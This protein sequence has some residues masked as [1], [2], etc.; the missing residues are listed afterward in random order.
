MG[1]R[2][3]LIR[4]DLNG[5]AFAGSGFIVSD[6]AVLTA[7]HVAAGTRHRV[8]LDGTELAVSGCV[9]SG[10]EEVDLAVLTLRHPLADLAPMPFAL[11]DRGWG[12]KLTGCWAIG[13]PRR[14]KDDAGRASRQVYGYIRPADG[15]HAAGKA[16]G[17]WLTLVGEE[18]SWGDALPDEAA[19][20]VAGDGGNPWGGMSGAALVKD[21]MVI[22]VVS[23][24]YQEKGPETLTVTPLTALKL[25]PASKQG[26]FRAA[27]GLGP[28]DHLPL[29]SGDGK[30]TQPA[31]AHAGA[32]VGAGSVAFSVDIRDRYRMRLEAAGLPV[33]D[34]WDEASLGNLL[35]TH[36]GQ[37][38]A[39]DTLEALWLGLQALSLLR[40]VG[41]TE[42]GLRKLRHLYRRHVGRWP[43]AASRE[44]MLV[45]AAAVS[46]VE[47]RQAAETGY[48]AEPLTALARFM[49]AVA[50]SA[51]AAPSLDHPDLRGLADWL[52]GPLIQQRTDAEDYLADV[53]DSRAWALIELV[54]E[55]SAERARPSGVVV[56][57]I[58]EHGQPET[59]RIPC[60]PDTDGTAEEIALRALREAVAGLP[61]GDVLV[62]LCLPRHWLDAGVERW[63]VVGVGGRYESMS[64][65]YEPRLRW[66]MH[67]HEPKLRGRLVKRF[68]AV[69][70]T[71]EPEPIPLTVT[72]D[73]VALQDW[74]DE[75]DTDERRLPPYLAGIEP[76]TG[77]PDALGTLLW[78]GY[79]FAVWFGPDSDAG[80]CT[81][82]TCLAVRVAAP[83]R[84]DQLPAE[85]AANKQLRARRPVIV[86]SDPEG[87]ADFR[88]PN[89]RGG[90][91][92]GGTAGRGGSTERTR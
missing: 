41:G 32:A 9:R 18:S 84:R 6:R 24:Y 33:P 44:D 59:R 51:K 86:W 52:T 72:G 21:D 29:L 62:D 69:D 42:L 73:P 50:G 66:A 90:T 76:G 56:D 17:A 36:Q 83:S 46:I 30:V 64:R 63:D 28:L 58:S 71:A 39:A 82:A 91:L 57:L 11:V 55:E 15:V 13:F 45:Q 49:L 75:R 5:A 88:L 77:G 20:L 19:G 61:D 31:P 7:D 54:A 25:L 37:D 22:G 23:R 53:S 81:D 87:R 26:E 79:G 1:I 65:H 14:S 2:Y 89:P 40:D 70:W 43:D 60:S 74:L 38:A 78:E 68:K 4:Y 27:L 35:R 12:G 3:V 16:D 48:S 47:R 80:A 67:R 34:R 10:A 8:V 85:L 92:R